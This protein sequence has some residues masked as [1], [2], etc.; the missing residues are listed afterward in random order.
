MTYQQHGLADAFCR[1]R[2]ANLMR[3]AVCCAQRETVGSAGEHADPGEVQRPK[4]YMPETDN[5]NEGRGNV[6]RPVH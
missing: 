4:R 1:G 2:R 5:F 6:A 3:A